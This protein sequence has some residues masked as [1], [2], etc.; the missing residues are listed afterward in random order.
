MFFVISCLPHGRR[1]C[2][3]DSDEAGKA[4]ILAGAHPAGGRAMHGDRVFVWSYLTKGDAAYTLV[5]GR[6]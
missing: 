3:P 4:S 5:Q 6:R 1:V 2:A